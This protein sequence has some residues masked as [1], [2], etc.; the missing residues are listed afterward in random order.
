M[1]NCAV[2]QSVIESDDTAV[3]CVDGYGNKRYL[4]AECEE[5][6]DTVT[7]GKDYTEI[8]EAINEIGKRMVKADITNKFTLKTVEEIIKNAKSRA[9]L[10]KDGSYDFSLDTEVSDI[11]DTVPEQLLETEEDKEADRVEAEKNKK[12][13]FW[14][15]IVFAVLIAGCVGFFLY[16]V[17][18]PLL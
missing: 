17:L 15:N 11:P 13:D 14:V 16:K 5:I 9:E 4:C 7:L 2:C 3:L 1:K 8:C 6:M 10:I 12:V 18:S